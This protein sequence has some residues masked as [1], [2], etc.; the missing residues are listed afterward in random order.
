MCSGQ[1]ANGDVTAL[2]NSN[3]AIV[4]GYLYE[5]YGKPVIVTP[6]PNGRVD[7]GNDD[8]TATASAVD[9]PYLYTGQRHDAD[10]GLYYYRA[11]YYDSEAGQFLSRDPIGTWTDPWSL[12]NGYGYAYGD[13]VSLRDPSGN[14][15]ICVT[16]FLGGV[17]GAVVGGVGYELLHH[18]AWKSADFWTAVGLGAASG[19][20]IGTGVGAAQGLSLAGGFATA[21]ETTSI[22]TEIPAEMLWTGNFVANAGAGSLALEMND[23]MANGRVTLPWQ[24]YA[25]SA[26]I[27]GATATLFQYSVGKL[28]PRFFGLDAGAG[29]GLGVGEEVI[30]GEYNALEVGEAGSPRL[31]VVD[32][33]ADLQA[34]YSRWSQGGTPVPAEGYAG[35]YVK[36]NDGTLVGWRTEGTTPGPSIDLKLPGEPGK[37]W[38]VHVK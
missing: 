18:G 22:A 23:L 13:P 28:W 10:T 2:T 17:L 35:Q 11:R 19:A 26:A 29:A 9:N 7:W 15:P 21:W 36:L 24:A 14:C 6:G 20:L 33:E 34:L 25:G 37:P 8:V 31:R 30:R 16:A 12:G 4:E 5:A 38:T 1:D 3:A 27:S 32:S